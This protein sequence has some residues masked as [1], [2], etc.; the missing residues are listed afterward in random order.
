MDGQCSLK[1]ARISVDA[2]SKESSTCVI[3]QRTEADGAILGG[4]VVVP[5]EDATPN[6]Q[7]TVN[8][9]EMEQKT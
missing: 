9:R 2:T 4:A 6:L 8:E 1:E 7:S 5:P 3:H